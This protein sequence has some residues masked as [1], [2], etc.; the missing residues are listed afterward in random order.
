[1]FYTYDQNNSGGGFDCDDNVC[2]HVIIEAADADD[3]DSRAEALGIYFNGVAAG[4]DCECCGDR[5]YPAS[6]WRD[7]TDTPQVYGKT[8]DANW[9]SKYSAWTDPAV[10]VHC[11]NGTK[12]TFSGE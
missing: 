2:Q 8:V 11:M 10:I 9:R 6:P 1:M 4:I 5:W 12:V 3:A 7:G